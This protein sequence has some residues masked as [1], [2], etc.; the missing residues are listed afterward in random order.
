VINSLNA[1][2]NIS[3]EEVKSTFTLKANIWVFL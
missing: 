1:L 3:L 2:E